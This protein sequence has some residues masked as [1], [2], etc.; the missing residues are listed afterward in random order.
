MT[1][2]K[3][4]AKIPEKVE[5]KKAKEKEVKKDTKKK[6]EEK[7][8]IFRRLAHF[9]KGVKTEGK[10]IKWPTKKDMV[11]YSLAAIF[12]IVFCAAFFYIIDVILA[13][14]HTLGK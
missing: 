8:N 6:K 14:L 2:K 3:E 9:F 7:E 5:K 11:K 4:E 10:R 1:K 12:F 13:L